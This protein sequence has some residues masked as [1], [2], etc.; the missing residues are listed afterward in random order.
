M[1]LVTKN[2]ELEK[3]LDVGG[4]ASIDGLILCPCH[5]D[6]LVEGFQKCLPSEWEMA[7]TLAVV[8]KK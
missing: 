1:N 7:D 2:L 8:F 3:W 6:R 4:R 5:L